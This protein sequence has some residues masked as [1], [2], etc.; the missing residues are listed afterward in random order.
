MMFDTGSIARF[1]GLIAALLAYFGVN[2]P[3][4]L[5][6]AVTSFVVAALAVYAAWKNNYI[7]KKGHEQKKVLEEA[8]LKKGKI[9]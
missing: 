3:G 9:E 1:F 4:D 2:V 7:S 6:E 8:G 5:T